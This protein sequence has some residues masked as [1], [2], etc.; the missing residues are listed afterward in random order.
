MVPGLAGPRPPIYV[1][2]PNGWV[3]CRKQARKT[4][5]WLPVPGS[6]GAGVLTGRIRAGASQRYRASKGTA[7][8]LIAAHDSALADAMVSRLGATLVERLSAGGSG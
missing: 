8:T 5:R 6:W 1:T 3:S 4:A 2:D 7:I